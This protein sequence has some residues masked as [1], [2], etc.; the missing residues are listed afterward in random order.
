[1]S[2]KSISQSF[3]YAVIPSIS[4]L[5]F[6]CMRR[7]FLF[8]VMIFVAPLIFTP[9]IYAEWSP[10]GLLF[11]PLR[12]NVFESRIASMYEF[13]ADKLRLDIGNSTDF[14]RLTKD[15]LHEVRFGTDFFTMTRLRSVGKFKFPVETSD[16]FFGV[17]ASAQY[18]DFST[19]FRL[20]HISSHLVDGSDSVAQRFFVYSREF[21][22]AV[23][24]FNINGL[25]PYAGLNFLFSKQ[26]RD[27]GWLTPQIGFDFTKKLAANIF[28]VG[29]YDF[30]LPTIHSTTTGVNTAQIGIKFGEQNGKGIL[31]NLYGYDGKSLHGMFY[32]QQ[33]SYIA[34]GF[35]V[36]F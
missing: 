25:R 22:D 30:K 3:V 26:P 11:T 34:F 2:K 10:E 21:F 8:F 33:D 35:Q 36:D 4:T 16:Y 15:S 28:I 29:G 20:A 18:G 9:E 23:G 1:M 19:R 32:N 24:T 27:F 17:N 7:F 12:A 5:K 14:Y 31:L 6:A 13:G